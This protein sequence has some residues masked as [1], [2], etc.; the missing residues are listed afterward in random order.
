MVVVGGGGGG[1]GLA[2][3]ILIIVLGCWSITVG[4]SLRKELLTKLLHS[5]SNF[6]FRSCKMKTKSRKGGRPEKKLPNL[7][8]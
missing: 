7:T 5:W 3:G 6:Y 2:K 4:A 8:I 1:D